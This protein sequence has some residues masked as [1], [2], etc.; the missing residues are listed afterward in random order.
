ME[1]GKR[2]YGYSIKMILLLGLVFLCLFSFAFSFATGKVARAED[3][4]YTDALSDLQK[5]EKFKEEDYPVKDS[6]YSLK[7]IQIA[8]SVNNELFVYVYQP[9]SPNEDLTATSVSLSIGIDEDY[10]P[11]LYKLELLNAFSVFGKY[12]VKNFY[13]PTTET[14]HYEIVSIFR[15][16]NK[17]Y[18]G[19]SGTNNTISEVSF[20]VGK[21]Y[22]ISGFGDDIS[23]SVSDVEIV[24]VTDKYVG[25]VRYNGGYKW[26]GF[27][28]AS[29]DNHFVA[30]STDH[31]IDVL[32]EADVY[33]TDRTYHYNKN[34][35][36]T[37]VGGSSSTEYGDLIEHQV[38]LKYDDVEDYKGNI[39]H[40]KYTWNKISTVEDFIENEN[41]T[42]VYH[43]K[44]I[45]SV[46]TETRLSV[47]GTTNIL[48][49]Q[50]VLRFATTKYDRQ[51]NDGKAPSGEQLYGEYEDIKSSQVM[52]VSILRLK[53]ESE[54]KVFNLG[55]V[56]NKQSGDLEPD[57]ETNVEF[58]PDKWLQAIIDFFKNLFSSWWKIL[59][60]IV[61]I[62][63]LIALLPVIF[64]FLLW[65]FKALIMIVW[66]V[67]KGVWW[68]I[69]L[70][71]KIFKKDN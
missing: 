31:D 44:L 14:R 53:F 1:K 54:G 10:K 55:V 47:E 71:F 24:R 30:F 17:K 40:K 34:G 15:N 20:E 60:F 65:L 3:I 5:D 32:L 27:T 43:V 25:F 68:L 37:L 41:T 7:V 57:N 48:E 59:V 18:D 61:V 51:Y 45:G 70:P 4:V 46:R 62:I 23:Y 6:D 16:W 56:D 64:P 36:P 2:K 50:W 19:S 35:G 11:I 58:K 8:E 12:K 52:D 39:F 28:Y 9:C 38:S 29:A 21:Q 42:F 22:T 63:A 69:T 13:I 66:Y 49:K 26:D 33:Y 67:L